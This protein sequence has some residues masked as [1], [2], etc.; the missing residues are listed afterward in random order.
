MEDA[1][2]F[3]VSAL[4]EELMREVKR[5]EAPQF[6]VAYGASLFLGS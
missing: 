3:F 4:E 1:E 5:F 6:T 2:I